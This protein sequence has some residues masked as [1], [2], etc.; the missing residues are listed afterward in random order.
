VL[1]HL[2]HILKT[3]FGKKPEVDPHMAEFIAKKKAEVA[4]P[5]DYPEHATVCKKCSTKAV[6]KMDGCEVCLS[7]G[8]SKCT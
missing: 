6:V 4:A 5:T 7:C 8:E 2:G 1:A 3:H